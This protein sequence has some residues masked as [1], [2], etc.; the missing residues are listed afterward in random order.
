MNFT[1][2]ENNKEELIRDKWCKQ[3]E[4]IVE[5]LGIKNFCGVKA[6]KIQ[7]NFKFS[8][9]DESYPIYLVVI[10]RDEPHKLNTD[11]IRKA[12]EDRIPLEVIV[13]AVACNSPIVSKKIDESFDRKKSLNKILRRITPEK[14]FE[15]LDITIAQVLNWYSKGTTKDRLKKMGDYEF[16]YLV[17]QEFWEWLYDFVIEGQTSYD[18]DEINRIKGSIQ[19]FFG[20]R[21]KKAYHKFLDTGYITE[22]ALPIK[23]IRRIDFDEEKMFDELKKDA[24]RKPIFSDTNLSQVVNYAIAELAW[25]YIQDIYGD[26]ESD[27]VIEYEKQ[28]E[29]Y[30]RSKYEDK[31]YM[32]LQDT[33]TPDGDKEGDRYIFIKHSERFGGLKST[34]FSEGFGTWNGLLRKYA[35]WFPDVN[36]NKIKSQFDKQNHTEIL[37]KSPGDRNNNMGYYFS[38]GKKTK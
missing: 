32:F 20:D 36:W 16:V 26:D 11:S 17:I 38:I 19:H 18:E 15:E 22:S 33:F 30:I 9:D 23:L 31:L 5:N 25:T 35:Y 1:I 34:G 8:W 37:I 21:I 2:S 7:E 24:L 13:T 27:E 12:I 6:W 10:E 14:F 29:N 28:L 3:L 4:W